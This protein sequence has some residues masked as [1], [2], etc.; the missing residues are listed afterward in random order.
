M[1]KIL[2]AVLAAALLAGCKT[3]P[4]E[5]VKVTITNGIELQTMTPVLAGYEFLEDDDPAFTEITLAES[6]RMYREKGSGILYYGREGCWWCQRVVPVLNEAAKEAGVLVYYVDVALPTSKE[7]Y[8]ELVSYIEGIFELDAS[9]GEPVFK[10]PEVIGVK[11]GEITGH[12]LS[13][14]SSF[15]PD[16]QD[17]LTDAQREELKQIYLDIFTA[18][19]D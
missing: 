5:P 7:S 9:T 12:H 13:L 19:A 3:G 4:K 11:N 18:T 10:V 15:D 2:T 14:V 6:I 8:D 16:K 17:M 1:K